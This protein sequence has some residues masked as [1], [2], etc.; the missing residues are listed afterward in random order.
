MLDLLHNSELAARYNEVP[1]KRQTVD[2]KNTEFALNPDVDFKELLGNVA[3]AR[4]LAKLSRDIV[5]AKSQLFNIIRG[6]NPT[7]RIGVLILLWYQK[8]M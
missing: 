6:S 7:Y 4:K 5:F 2:T 1:H 8:N 3:A